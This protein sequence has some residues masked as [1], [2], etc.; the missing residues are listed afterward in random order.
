MPTIFE[1]KNINALL[2]IKKRYPESVIFSGGVETVLKS[3]GKQ[4]AL[5]ES[6]IYIGNVEELQKMKRSE[7]YLEIGAA[8]KVSQI[9]DKGK[10]IIPS[11]LLEAM[12]KITPPNFKNLY[13]I[14]GLIC[15]EIERNSIFSV[16]CILDAKLEI[17]SASTSRWVSTSSLFG[18]DSITL[19]P[20]EIVTKIRIFLSDFDINIHRRIENDYSI[21]GG[22]ISF[23]AIAN[24][25][26]GNINFIKFIY[27]VSDIYVIRSKEVESELTG[28]NLPVS[29]K[30]FSQ[31][32]THFNEQ[33]ESR[34]GSMKKYRKK[35]VSNTFEWF[36][37]ELSLY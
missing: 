18:K 33:L 27:S 20:E 3:S 17:R 36:L 25:L 32:M 16:L 15:S 5:P 8:A 19:A 26:K 10:N 14:G 9:I 13:T 35:I 22:T 28:L 24:I 11:I 37:N 1:P 23:S 30:N 21:N 4:L 7:R 29:D 31:V 2:N 34:H 6:L 12:K